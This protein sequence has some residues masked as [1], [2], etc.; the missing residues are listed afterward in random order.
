MAPASCARDGPRPHDG[1]CTAEL[2][3]E[4]AFNDIRPASILER[5]GTAIRARQAPS[6]GQAAKEADTIDAVRG[7]YTKQMDRR[8][9]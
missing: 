4:I 5:F 1:L 3:V 2:M 6:A 8:P 7:L 9:P